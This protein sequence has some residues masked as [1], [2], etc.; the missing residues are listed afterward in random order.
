MKK[1]LIALA[2]VAVT[3]TAMA[4]VTISG[5]LRVALE[6]VG[7]VGAKAK[8][9]SQ[10]GGS[11][12]ITF[13]STEDLGGGLTVTAMTNIRYSSVTGDSAS[14][15]SSDTVVANGF[16]QNVKLS[17]AGGF[18]SVDF[19]RYTVNGLAGFDAWGTVGAGSAYLGDNGGRYSNAAQY[20]SPTINGFKASIAKTMTGAAAGTEEMSNITIQ[21]ATG[22]MAFLVGKE[23]TLALTAA[24]TTGD[25]FGASYDMGVAK[26]MFAQSS[27]KNTVTG[28]KSA[29][30]TA[31][32]AVIPMGAATFKV[33]MTNDK[34]NTTAATDTSKTAFGVDY[35]LS[36][37]TKVFADYAKAKKDAQNQFAIG[38]AHSF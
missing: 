14:G 32:S 7:T 5:G 26:V 23:K 16:A 12:A 10:D 28:V 30:R 34:F 13:S 1:T 37:R 3:S 9:V 19:G 17:V 21:Y 36:K 22:P 24:Q 27:T 18:G 29:D 33:G 25:V 35:A 15:S 38:M 2:A 8:M 4:Q 11:N 6:R 20:N 31:L